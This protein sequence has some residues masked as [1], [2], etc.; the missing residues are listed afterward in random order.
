MGPVAQVTITGGTSPYNFTV[1]GSAK[2]G[3]TSPYIYAAGTATSCSLTTVTDANGCPVPSGSITG[4][5][6]TISD[7]ITAGGTSTTCPV[8]TVGTPVVFYDASGNLMGQVTATT[9]SLGNVAFYTDALDATVQITGHSTT[10]KQSYLQRHFHIEPTNNN[11]AQISLYILSSEASSLASYSST[12]DN[13]TYYPTFNIATNASVD[14]YDAGGVMANETPSGYTGGHSGRTVIPFSSLT[15]TQTPS[16]SSISYSNVYQLKFNI[17]SF[18]GFYINAENPGDNPLPVTLLF[19]TANPVNNKYIQLEWATASEINNKGFEI[20]RSTDGNDFTGIGFVAGHGTVNAL[21]S[22][23]FDDY[24]AEPSTTYYYR[25]RQEDEN[26]NSTYSDIVSAALIAPQGF[27]F[28]E[29]MPNPATDEVKLGIVSNINSNATVTM[30]DMLGRDILKTDLQLS[31]GYNASTYD[32]TTLP[33][34]TYLVTISSGSIKISK[35]LVI[36]K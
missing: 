3:Q 22:Y 20:E 32:L 12:H 34:G 16:V 26:G 11:T 4:S 24:T 36:A 35:K 5:P 17:S 10:N 7:I 25:L 15:I 19:V 14:K 27:A 18:S 13:H 21:E 33:G 31:I 23:A 1:G 28:T 8:T 6:L 30:T 29:M 2:T 9:G